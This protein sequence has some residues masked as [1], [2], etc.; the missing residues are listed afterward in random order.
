MEQARP[1]HYSISCVIPAFNEGD[2]ITEFLRELHEVLHTFAERVEIIVVNDG[3]RDHTAA[4]VAA[5]AESLSLTLL[6]LS[7]NFGKEAAITAGLARGRGDVVLIIDADGQEPLSMIGPMLERW[8]DGCDMVY[9]VRDGRAD[10]R[11]LKR[12]G[13]G[14][15]YSL[16]TRGGETPIPPDARD[17]RIMDRRV[18]DALNRLPERN[19]FMKGLFAWV[20]FKTCAVPV[21]IEARKGGRSS[22][23]FSQLSRLALTGITS[24]T[25]VPLRIWGAIGVVISLLAFA[26]GT[27]IAL[28]TLFFGVDIPGFATL[29]VS[30][31]FFAGIQLIS[32]GVIGEYLSRVFDEVKQR[33]VYLVADELD[34]SPLREPGPPA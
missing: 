20:G 2:G 13:A 27:Y 7:R 33:P 16:L 1:V 25:N 12:M 23:G 9:A 11:W 26:Y 32:I 19:R 30:I 31:M 15:F 4:A 5:I 17:F 18:V 6:D 14:F 24:F 8:R 29:A 28:R 3:S 22:F 21:K 34:H 10:E